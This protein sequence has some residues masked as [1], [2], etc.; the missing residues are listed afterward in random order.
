MSMVKNTALKNGIM[1]NG[2]LK[3]ETPYLKGKRHGISKTYNMNGQLLNEEM[4]VN[5]L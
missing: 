2:K 5:D 1:K 3:E 4:W